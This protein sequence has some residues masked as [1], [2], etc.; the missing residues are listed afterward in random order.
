[1]PDPMPPQRSS[2]LQSGALHGDG[3]DEARGIHMVCSHLT[4]EKFELS[5]GLAGLLTWHLA[6]SKRNGINLVLSSIEISE[7]DYSSNYI[8]ATDVASTESMYSRRNPE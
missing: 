3:N 7:I 8:Y 5:F 1:M 2:A 4:G 6:F